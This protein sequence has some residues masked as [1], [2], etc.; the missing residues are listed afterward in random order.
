LLSRYHAHVDP[1]APNDARAL[2]LGMVGWNKRVLELGAASGHVTRVLAE[3]HCDVTA[4][5]YEPEVA[6]E[7]EGVA[8][9]V[10]VGDLDDDAVLDGLPADFDVVLAGDVLEHLVDPGRVL[11]R[12]AR[13]V[14]PG[15]R[16][17]ISLPNIA[18][19]DVRMALLQGRWEYRPWG[20]MDRTHLRFFTLDGL[21]AMVA[22]A[23]PV[24]TELRRVRI[25]AFESEVAVP[26]E[27]VPTA[28][29]DHILTDPEAETYQFVVAA[30]RPGPDDQARRVAAERQVLEAELELARIRRRARPARAGRRD[31]RPPR[32]RGR[33]A[34]RRP[35][36]A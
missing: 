6:R 17:V 30:I 36:R 29:L 35:R 2:A 18:H 25:P 28:V 4:V 23:G 10:I 13:L 11:R 16:V 1:D 34:L 20:L 31:D 8:A 3:R 21:Y 7:L 5:E 19:A 24:A 27:S 32:R 22:E 12:A 9:G 15:G 33:A 14:V 26:R